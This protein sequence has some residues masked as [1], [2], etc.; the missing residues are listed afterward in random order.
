MGHESPIARIL[1]GY[2]QRVVG[3]R[4]VAVIVAGC[5]AGVFAGPADAGREPQ[6]VG[7]T[8][9]AP[10][11]WPWMA[12]VTMHISTSG[13]AFVGSCGG[14]LIGERWVLTA[15]H[16]LTLDP[17]EFGGGSVQV[18]SVQVRIGASDLALAGGTTLTSTAFFP[19]P[20]FNL[21]TTQ[22]DFA[23]IRLPAA[24]DAQAIGLPTTADAALWAPGT[25][26]TVTGWG[27]LTESGQ[28]DSK[29]RQVEVPIVSAE[30]CGSTV[31]YG[32][33]FDPASMLCAGYPEGGR[34]SCSGDSGGPLVVPA[35]Q[36]SWLQ[37]GITSWGDG[38][39]RPNKPGVYSA[40][41]A[42][43]PSILKM[44]TTD[45]VAPVTAPAA[46]TGTASGLTAGG[47]TVSGDIVP[48]GLATSFRIDYGT[49]SS[50]GS[51]FSAY[52]G[53]GTSGE[54]VKAALT[55][56]V[57][58]TTY[59]YRIA[60]TSGAGQATGEDRTFRTT[61]LAA[62]GKAV[63]VGTRARVAVTCLSGSA[64]TCKGTVRI[65]SGQLAVGKT[66]VSIA[67]GAVAKVLVP[68]SNA[69]RDRLDA[70]GRLPVKTTLTVH[71]GGLSAT[72]TSTSTLRR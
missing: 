15:A 48:G 57:P 44:L 19:N 10:G 5:L 23:L 45:P 18:T 34:D 8:V 50:Y 58:S 16:C 14:S 30:T 35:G 56:L 25:V 22:R 4:I 39:A 1:R 27:A 32:S 72:L 20:T 64:G 2:D 29:L 61:A 62:L 6:I 13:G 67:S 33:E 26:A 37:A 7:G 41:A 47:A 36:D 43:L 3:R 55:G 54:D 60:A 38:C 9:A 68:L 24:I 52:A 63:L 21:A 11:A 51:S 46:T 70:T 40:V 69:A 49:T 71:A 28:F 17:A 12:D 31:Y 59:H 66:K 65:T 42:L 53:A